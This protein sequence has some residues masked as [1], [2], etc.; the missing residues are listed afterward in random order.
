MSLQ[1]SQGERT[2]TIPVSGMTCAS[3]TAHVAE[4]LKATPGV[5]DAT[6]N[7]LLETAHVRFDRAGE[8]RGLAAVV[9]AAG[10]RSEL[11]EAEEID[12]AEA[13]DLEHAAEYRDLAVK[14][15]VSLAAAALGM[16][17]S[18]PVMSA[19]AA[20]A[21]H[22]TATDPLMQWSHSL[23]RLVAVG[24]AA[25]ALRH[26]C[27]RSAVGADGAH[28]SRD[29]LGRT[30]LLHARRGRRLVTTLRT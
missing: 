7:L 26:E 18:M 14:A 8:A 5:K 6:V 15:I 21:H 19:I 29:G 22:A 10:Y 17:L 25:M 4:A 11:S 13:R 12:D 24:R 30:A 16:L 2:A 28:R 23:A 1:T 20:S 9:R 27:P 3:C